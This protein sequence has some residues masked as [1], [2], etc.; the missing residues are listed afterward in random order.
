MIRPRL[1]TYSAPFDVHP[2]RPPLGDVT[3]AALFLSPH[4]RARASSPNNR[5]W[6]PV[7][8]QPMQT[9]RTVD[10]SLVFS[11]HRQDGERA[12]DGDCLLQIE[13]DGRSILKAE[14]VALNFLQHLSGIATLTRRF[15]D[16]ARQIPCD[17][18]R[19]EKDDPGLPCASEMGGPP[20][21]GHESPPVAERRRPHQG[22]SSG[23]LINRT[24][25]PVRTACRKAKA[26]APRNMKS[27]R[28]SG[29]V[30]RCAAGRRRT[31]RPSFCWIT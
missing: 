17:H 24:T 25:M 30:G 15:C 31:S 6:S 9:F 12:K 26:N 3:T 4:Q 28:G 10:A 18:P 21:R 19:H 29:I 23:L 13:G 14:R 22:Q 1:P 5:W 8:P 27:Y 20:R 2:R 7:L 11:I 16:A